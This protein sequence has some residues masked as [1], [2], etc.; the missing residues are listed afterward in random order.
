MKKGTQQGPNKSKRSLKGL[1]P[2][3]RD[4][5][6]EIGTLL[7]SVLGQVHMTDSDTV[8]DFTGTSGQGS[9]FFVIQGETSLEKTPIFS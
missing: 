8:T 9:L 1:N 2:S 3:N 5:F 6:P 4:Q 7:C